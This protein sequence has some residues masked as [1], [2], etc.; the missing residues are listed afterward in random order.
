MQ[1]WQCDNPRPLTVT[2]DGPTPSSHSVQH[3]PLFRPS[4]SPL[5]PTPGEAPAPLKPFRA[6][7]PFC[8]DVLR[9]F[10]VGEN[11]AATVGARNGSQLAMVQG[12]GV[13]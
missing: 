4:L 8:P 7:P 1:S 2:I 3:A 6:C 5:T 12:M 11:G 10:I 9:D 13:L